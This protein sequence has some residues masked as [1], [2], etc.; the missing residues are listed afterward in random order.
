M[1]QTVKPHYWN[2]ATAYLASVDPALEYIIT[3]YK[4]EF[5]A[6]LNDPFYTLARSI[7]GQQIS[8]KAA[9]SVWAKLEATLGKVEPGRLMALNDAELRE[10]G[11]SRSKVNYL[12]HIAIAMQEK[13]LN[14][15]GW[16]EMDDHAVIRELVAIKGVGRWTA[17]MF[18]IFHLH[19]PDVFPIADLG[20]I[21]AIEKIYGNGEKLEKEDIL[22]IAEPWKP[23]RTVATWY[24]WRSLDPVAVQY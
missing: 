21:K 20:L 9:D 12:R 22:D 24:L 6:N 15:A 13:R 18:L 17:E 5:M 8:V 16:Q 10:C 4:G 14:P 23:Y 11:L 2:E 3:H 7:V 1:R 19:R